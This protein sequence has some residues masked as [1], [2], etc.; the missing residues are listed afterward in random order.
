MA[1]AK[2]VFPVPGGPNNNTPFH[3]LLIP[4]NKCGIAR[5]SK[6]AYSRT[7]FA[8]YSSAISSKAILGLKSTTYLSSILISSASGPLPSG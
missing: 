8:F 7:S 4:V 5:G 6:T 3:A 2:S 1:F